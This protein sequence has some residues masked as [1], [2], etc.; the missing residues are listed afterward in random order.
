MTKKQNML[1]SV[2][3]WD[4]VA[5]GYAEIT[6]KLFQGYTDKALELAPLTKQSR[7][8]DI[9]CGPGTLA[10]SAAK[11]VNSVKAVDFSESMLAI[12]QETIRRQTI[13]NIETYFGDA[14]NL[15][16][17]DESFDAAFSMFGLM[18]FPDRK[19]GYREIYRTL[20]PGG[21]MVVSSWAP[22]SQ[23]PAMMAMFGALKAVNPDIPDPQTDIESLENPDFFKTELLAAGFNGAEM[24]LVTQSIEID[25]VEKFW[26]DMVKGSA[27]IVMLK[28]SLSDEAWQEKCQIAIGY[29]NT[30]IGACP[31]SL[32]MDAWLGFARKLN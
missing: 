14:Q 20:K 23:S 30:A 32:S 4:M 15:P 21:C 13:D 10:L 31:T 1:S 7:I 6:M 22:V 17:S 18:F 9:A 5:E 16:Y 3:P 29:L 27:P 25:S 24:H 2:T 19:K 26:N 28:N 12:L 11:R 8:V